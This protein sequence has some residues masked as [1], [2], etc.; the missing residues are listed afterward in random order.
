MEAAA[1]AG[2][3]TVFYG[4]ILRFS[5]PRGNFL[6]SKAAGGLRAG[7]VLFRPFPGELRA[8]A[9]DDGWTDKMI[10]LAG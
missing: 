8:F 4:D 7:Q 3:P 10:F 5:A 1:D 9:T 6:G 2:L